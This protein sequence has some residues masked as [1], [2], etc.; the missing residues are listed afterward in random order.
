MLIS[1]SFIVR[2]TAIIRR[3][4]YHDFKENHKRRIKM[5]NS[6][7]NSKTI[8]GYTVKSAAC[9]RIRLVGGR[10]YAAIRSNFRLAAPLVITTSLILVSCATKDPVAGLNELPRDDAS[11]L[12]S[13]ANPRILATN[14]QKTD[15]GIA[16]QPSALCPKDWTITFFD[17]QI[18]IPVTVCTRPADRALLANGLFPGSA[19][20]SFKLTD[21]TNL[22][23]LKNGELWQPPLVCTENNGPWPA[24]IRVDR[25]CIGV[26]KPIN[27]LTVVG[28]P[29]EVAFAWYGGFQDHPSDFEFVGT[30]TKTGD[31]NL[32]ECNSG[33]VPAPARP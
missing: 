3:S 31:E 4:S 8:D 32:G 24:R 28:I 16:D 22:G 14:I 11:K 23:Q 5:E 13:L 1:L 12:Q 27:F 18:T 20:R 6:N 26:C 7:T 17:A 29:N 19:T 25:G 30:P 21:L 2:S 10:L 33:P 9:F 15:L